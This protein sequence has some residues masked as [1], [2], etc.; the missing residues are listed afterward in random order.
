MGVES[1]CAFVFYNQRFNR[2]NSHSPSHSHSKM[3][4]GFTHKSSAVLP[5]FFCRIF[6]HCAV[7]DGDVLIQVASD[8]IR[9]FPVGSAEIRRLE[10][11]GWF[12]VKRD[13]QS[14]K[15]N[16]QFLTCVGFAKRALGI[17]RPFIWTPDGLFRFLCCPT[18]QSSRPDPMRVRR[19]DDF[20]R[21][22][23]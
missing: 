10:S 20:L 8:G 17:R 19:D 23:F 5:R 11:A 13:C 1:D 12:F 4:I 15:F 22:S 14:A 21:K 16:C 9:C 18:G 6:R 3:L 2:L 7:V